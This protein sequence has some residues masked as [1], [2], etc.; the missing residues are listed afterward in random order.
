MTRG[1][2][3]QVFPCLEVALK[4]TIWYMITVVKC[5]EFYDWYFCTLAKHTIGWCCQN[6]Y[7][8]LYC[9]SYNVCFEFASIQ[10]LI[11][12]CGDSVLQ[13]YP[14]ELDWNAIFADPSRP[15]IVDIGSGIVHPFSFL[16]KMGVALFLY[17]FWK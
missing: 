2:T 14:F 7:I 13:A 15:L 9:V 16:F 5:L 8:C 17:C 12:T 4:L 11:I 6:C 3:G 1:L 10:C